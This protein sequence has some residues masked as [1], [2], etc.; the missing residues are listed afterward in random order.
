MAHGHCLQ[1][2]LRC[3]LV[4]F[5]KEGQP[6]RNHGG[7]AVPFLGGQCVGGPFR[8]DAGGKQDFIRIDIADAGDHALVQQAFLDGLLPLS[9]ARG[10][11]FPG[12]G[13]IKGL[14][15]QLFHP[16]IW[17]CFPLPQ[18]PEAPKPAHV[19]ETQL[20]AAGQMEHKMRMLF[21]RDV[22]R[23]HQQTA[24][25]PQMQDE[26]V[27]AFHAEDQEFPPAPGSGKNLAGKPPAECIG[28]RVRD[29]FRPV[30]RDPFN[31]EPPNLRLD[32]PLDRFDFRQFRHVRPPL[33]LQT[34]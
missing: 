16:G 4:L 17:I 27:A 25:H 11:G 10:Q 6:L 13:G 12:E 1:I 20:L 33:S 14:R 18:Q 32:H 31:G 29:H 19:G 24:G 2:L 3:D 22:C 8:M 15:S 26:P 7:E 5:D 30:D 34:F 28:G 9:Q 23:R 21:F